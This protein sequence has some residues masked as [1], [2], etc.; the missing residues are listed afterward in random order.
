[1]MFTIAE[2]DN[3]NDSSEEDETVDAG[4]LRT[5][6]TG[7]SWLNRI[8]PSLQS[9]QGTSVGES[10]RKSPRKSPGKSPRKSDGNSRGSS[11]DPSPVKVRG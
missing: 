5:T 4:E 1:M 10:P 7:Q 11:A 3:E 8:P 6:E 9:A 2:S